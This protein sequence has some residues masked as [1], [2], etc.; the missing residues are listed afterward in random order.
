MKKLTLL[1]IS[2]LFIST[3]FAQ[4]RRQHNTRGQKRTLGAISMRN[5][6]LKPAQRSEKMEMMMAFRLTEELDLT[7]EQA[8]QFFPRMKVHRENMDKIDAS[9]KVI[10]KD[11]NSKTKSDYLLSDKE[12]KSFFNKITDLE[13][14][15]VKE[16]TRFIT[17][18][19]GTLD[20]NQLFKLSMFKH[21]FTR[22][23]KEVIRKK[24]RVRA[25]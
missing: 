8:D 6:M 12:F 25:N 7:P 13:L 2:I 23:M 15:K 17:E 19:D 1:L 5:N 14:E 11:A 24:R 18:L 20:N 4:P 16:R 22:D 21:K 10:V 9:I 3:V